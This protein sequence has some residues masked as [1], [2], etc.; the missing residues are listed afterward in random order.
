MATVVLKFSSAFSWIP[1]KC[2]NKVAPPHKFESP[3]RFCYQLLEIK[4]VWSW[5]CVHTDYMN[6]GQLV[7][8][9][10]LGMGRGV[11]TQT[12][13]WSHSSWEWKETNKF[14]WSIRRAPLQMRPLCSRSF[15]VSCSLLTSPTLRHGSPCTCLLKGQT[16]YFL[17]L[18]RKR[19]D[20]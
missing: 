16:S 17:Y 7:K 20:V 9:W 2:G 19:R 8:N 3:L 5:G 18:S 11:N 6:T 14:G 12:N 15:L 1:Q 10:G 13:W 4:K